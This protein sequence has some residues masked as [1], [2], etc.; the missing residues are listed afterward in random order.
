MMI[1]LNINK[2]KLK[3]TKVVKINMT[4]HF[5]QCNQNQL[6][7]I[8]LLYLKVMSNPNLNPKLIVL[9]KMN[10]RIE[11]D[12]SKQLVPILNKE[13]YL[14]PIQI[15]F[16]VKVEKGLNKKMVKVQKILELI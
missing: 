9:F 4:L 16:K 12:Q 10:Q 1:A 6:R 5:Q 14:K 2:I 7:K 11:E 13:N 15:Q 3:K 8:L